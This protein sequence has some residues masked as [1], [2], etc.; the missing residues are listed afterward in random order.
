M[1]NS[2]ITLATRL[3]IAGELDV[4]IAYQLA[5]LT[6][7]QG[8]KLQNPN[9]LASTRCLWMCACKS[10]VIPIANPSVSQTTMDVAPTAASACAPIPL[11]DNDAVH[12]AV[13]LLKQTA[14]CQWNIKQND[15]FGN[16]AFCHVPCLCFHKFTLQ[17]FCPFFSY[18]RLFRFRRSSTGRIPPAV[19]PR[20]SIISTCRSPGSI[21]PPLK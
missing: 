14:N 1:K 7:P 2:A 10:F 19:C 4:G 12:K 3:T 15:I 11:P 17:N 16:A 9:E 13:K 21:P 8:E 20:S 6:F 18:Q 5:I